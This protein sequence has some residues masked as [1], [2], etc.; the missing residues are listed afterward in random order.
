MSDPLSDE[1]NTTDTALEQ[2]TENEIKHASDAEAEVA[3]KS[4]AGDDLDTEES[5]GGD[6]EAQ[7]EID[8]IIE[9]EDTHPTSPSKVNVMNLLVGNEVSSW[10]G[11]CKGWRMHTVKTLQPPKPPKA[12]CNACRTIHQVRLQQPGTKSAKSDGPKL[13]NVAPW[14]ELVAGIQSA[15]AR[16]YTITGGYVLDEFVMHSKFGL[17]K[18]IQA[19]HERRVLI[20]FETGIKLMSQNYKAR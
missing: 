15:D 7:A 3:T 9:E 18:I 5:P 17:G 8:A 6:T 11:K 20:S 16:P 10:C 14:A 12:N 2:E 4:D 13:P 1:K 19:S